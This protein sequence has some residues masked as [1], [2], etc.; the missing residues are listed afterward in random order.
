MRPHRGHRE[1]QTRRAGHPDGAEIRVAD[2]TVV[3]IEAYGVDE[4]TVERL[5]RVEGV[6]SVSVEER[7]QAQVLLVQSAE[8]LEL[9]LG[10]WQ[11]ALHPRRP[12]GLSRTD[13]RGCLRLARHAQPRRCRDDLRPGRSAVLRRLEVPRQE[14]VAV[15]L[16]RA[17][18]GPATGAVREHRLLHVALR[19]ARGDVAGGGAWRGHDGHVDVDAVW[20]RRRHPVAALAGHAGMLLATPPPFV[21]ALLPLTVATASVGLYS[22]TATLAWGWLLFDMPVALAHPLTFAVALP[23]AVLSLGMLG[24]LLGSSFV[25][26]RNANALSNLLEYPVWLVTGLLVPL[27]L[28]PGWSH[29]IA[30]VL[31]PTWG[32]RAI[33]DAAIG[34][35]AWPEI[36]MCLALGLVYVALG[37]VW[38]DFFEE[39]RACAR[40]PLA[41]MTAQLRLFWI[42]G[43]ISYRA[44]FNWISPI[45][46]IPTML[47]SPLFQILF[48]AYLGRTAG[49]PTTSSRSATRCRSARW[50]ASTA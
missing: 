23:V 11:G 39:A 10:C 4:G 31:A 28:L 45:M 9:T 29:P 7:E 49:V 14:P 34:G 2:R 12:G 16:L 24:L 50:P 3:E 5:R 33:R 30:W 20:L 13:A 37:V 46:Y 8:G 41:D 25:M 19:P 26:Y 38:L 48:F 18:L 44:L 6:A 22:V 43:I 21:L 42:G 47:G 15:G 36:A 35:N 27:S 32:V 1:G 40:D 17:H